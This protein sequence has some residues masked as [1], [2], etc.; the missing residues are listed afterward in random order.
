MRLHDRAQ[1]SLERVALVTDVPDEPEPAAGSQHSVDLREGGVAI[2]PVE[3]L[4]DRDGVDGP[5]S[6]RDRL[7]RPV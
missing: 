7:S 4:R 5:V 3:R 6:E 2:E 1:P